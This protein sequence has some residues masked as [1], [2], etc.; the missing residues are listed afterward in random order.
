MERLLRSSALVTAT[1][2]YVL[3]AV[4]P[5]NANRFASNPDHVVDRSIDGQFAPIGELFALTTK[6]GTT[7][8]DVGTGFLIS[9]SWF[10]FN[11][12]RS[13]VNSKSWKK[14]RIMRL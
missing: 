3:S 12:L 10:L 7:Q 13:T 14:F 6:P 5:A 11:N 1:V 2:V 8:T 4:T 9:P